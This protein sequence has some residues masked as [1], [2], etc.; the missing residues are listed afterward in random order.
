[1]RKLCF[2]AALGRAYVLSWMGSAEELDIFYG[3]MDRTGGGISK[4]YEKRRSYSLDDK[5]LELD[6]ATVDKNLSDRFFAISDADG[7][8]RNTQAVIKI[9]KTRRGKVR[10]EF[11]YD[12]LDETGRFSIGDGGC[13]K[14]EPPDCTALEAFQQLIDAMYHD[15]EQ[16]A[17]KVDRPAM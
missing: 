5:R 13:N 8:F 3:D 9:E 4:A 11:Y 6:I 10:A 17:S 1:M 14:A 7:E 2:F 16:A 12:E 15:E